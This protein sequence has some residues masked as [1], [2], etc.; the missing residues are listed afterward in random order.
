MRGKLRIVIWIV[1][2]FALGAT[3][4]AAVGPRVVGRQFPTP[5][6][7][8]VPIPSATLFSSPIMLPKVTL[9]PTETL[10]PTP[11]ETKIDLS[12]LSFTALGPTQIL[13]TDPNGN[14]TGFDPNASV[15]IQD[16]PNSSYA[17]ERGHNVEGV[18][19]AYIK[20]P[21][22]GAYELEVIAPPNQIYGFS[23]H[24][25]DRDVNLAMNLFERRPAAG[26]LDRYT[27]IYDPTP[28]ATI[29]ALEVAIDIQP[30]GDLNVIEYKYAGDDEEDTCEIK[31]GGVGFGGGVLPAAVLTSPIFDA[32][33]VDASTVELGDP[34]LGRTVMPIGSI[35]GDVDRDGDEDLLLFFCIPDM[36][37]DGALDTNS[38]DLV[39]TGEMFDGASVTGT[40]SVLILID[41]DY[42]DD[43]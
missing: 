17:F 42:E 6:Q 4:L 10:V 9:E 22:A 38:T 14:Q 39:L 28:G 15:A 20:R 30:D 12:S 37:A 13:V 7:V 31:E 24:A 27:F 11:T 43:N 40:D 1:M 32:Q 29:I 34:A 41:E 33:R 2:I 26:E 36:V 8:I 25:Y 3:I 35:A 19:T 5:T 21:P 23:Y 18:Y 16:I